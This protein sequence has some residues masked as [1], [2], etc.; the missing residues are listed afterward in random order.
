MG[1]RRIPKPLSS[2]LVSCPVCSEGLATQSSAP[3]AAHEF[4]CEACG[5]FQA[6]NLWFEARLKT[7]LED[8]IRLQLSGAIRDATDNPALGRCP[9]EVSR[10]T[11]LQIA[12]RH[13]MPS[14]PLEQLDRLVEL[15]AKR[16]MFVGELVAF[17]ERNALAR[18][19]YLPKNADLDPFLESAEK[20]GYLTNLDSG[21][22][23]EVECS[24]TLKGWK[25]ADE[26][27]RSPQ[28]STQAFVAMWFHSDMDH[29]FEQGLKPALV[30]CGYSDY[31]VDRAAHQ[32]RIDDEIIA[33][34]RKSRIMIADFTGMRPNVFYEAG[35]AMGLGIPVI[36]TCNDSYTG[37]LLKCSPDGP[38]PKPETLSWFK[39]VSESAFDVRQYTFIPWKT[40]EELTR[41]LQQRIEALGLSLA[42]AAG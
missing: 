40:T 21:Y 33:N 16:S 32:N 27:R 24:L 23:G 8:P 6:T 30:A 36:F 9:E 34:I 39:Q 26:I 38:V 3:G 31:R 5:S 14:T 37:H 17:G 18:R 10:D 4:G 20:V 22:D 35:F 11:Y 29:V 12:A 19:L 13:R 1:S 2:P 28:N 41:A 7:P 15:V 25:R 42:V